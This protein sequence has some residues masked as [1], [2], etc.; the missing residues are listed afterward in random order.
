MLQR[1]LAVGPP[2]DPF[3]RE[4]DRVAEEVAGGRSGAPSRISNALPSLRRMAGTEGPVEAPDVVGE[5]LR[6]PGQPLGAGVR[7]FME[8]RIGHDFSRVRVHTNELAARSARSVNAL[9]YTVGSDVVFRDGQYAPETPAGRGCSP[10]SDACRAAG[11]RSWRGQDSSAGP[12]SGGLTGKPLALSGGNRASRVRPDHGRGQRGLLPRTGARSEESCGSG[13][14][15][16]GRFR[17]AVSALREGRDRQA[18]EREKAARSRERAGQGGAQIRL[19]FLQQHFPQHLPLRFQGLRH[20][21]LLGRSGKIQ[22]DR[23]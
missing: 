5:A 4:A 6:S 18:V 23:E 12:R 10:T 7:A 3:E 13:Y 17:F 14:R 19:R 8:P 1:K 9:A 16:Q 20:Q 2:G 21:G 11:R 15:P 22:M